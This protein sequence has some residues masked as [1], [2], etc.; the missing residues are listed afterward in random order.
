M[1]RPRRRWA[2]ESVYWLEGK[3]TKPLSQFQIRFPYQ[4]KKLDEVVLRI[5]DATVARILRAGWAEW[6]ASLVEE[7]VQEGMRFP[8]F[9][10]LRYPPKGYRIVRTNNKSR[11]ILV[12][13]RTCIEC[14][15]N[16]SYFKDWRSVY[17]DDDEYSATCYSCTQAA[18]DVVD[19]EIQI[20]GA[21]IDETID[22]GV[23]SMGRFDMPEE[24]E[25]QTPMT[26]T[27]LS[28]VLGQ[29]ASDILSFLWSMNSIS[30]ESSTPLKENEAK[31]VLNRFGIAFASP[32]GEEV[33]RRYRSKMSISELAK[34]T[35]ISVVRIGRFRQYVE[36]LDRA[37]AD[38]EEIGAVGSLLEVSFSYRLSIMGGALLGRGD[39]PDPEER[40][41]VP[42]QELSIELGRFNLLG[43]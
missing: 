32:V 37:I 33:L 21:R 4:D 8:K 39:L 11:T 27:E 31:G 26:A 14:G 30:I 16:V 35:G 15:T 6:D 13:E 5:D 40:D 42:D 3:E 22:D 25:E 17:I 23:V 29:P 2:D 20:W 10:I 9:G 19:D 41:T 36:Q 28:P 38:L 18:D 34:A 7:L 24:E 1:S 43:D 12:V